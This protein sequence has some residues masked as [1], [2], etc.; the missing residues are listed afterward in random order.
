MLPSTF[1]CSSDLCL[2]LGSQISA[3]L[4]GIQ[5][6]LREDFISG[7]FLGVANLNTEHKKI[8]KQK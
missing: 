2:L 6:K 4:L 8:L 7:F 5:P 1:L 3:T